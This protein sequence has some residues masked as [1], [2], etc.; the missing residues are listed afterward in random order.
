MRHS[1]DAALKDVRIAILATHG[2]EQSELEIPLERL[3]DAGAHVDVVSLRKGLIRGWQNHDWGSEVAVDKTL[4]EIDAAHYAALVLPGGQ[5]NPDLLRV[6]E[7]AVELVREFDRLNKPIA[8][9][10]HGPWL[11]VEA[12]LLRG[13]NVTC[14]KS[15]RT[16]VVNAGGNYSDHEVVVDDNFIT[17]RRPDDLEAFCSALIEKLEERNSIAAE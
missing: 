6:D 3:R 14:Y 2:F 16:D 4:E 15:I 7:H 9:I 8:A 12:G 17:S 1:D 13:R 11:L 10:C 5:M